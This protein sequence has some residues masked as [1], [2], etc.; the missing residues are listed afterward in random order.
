MATNGTGS[1]MRTSSAIWFTRRRAHG[2]LSPRGPDAHAGAV[3]T[4]PENKERVTFSQVTRQLSTAR[5]RPDVAEGFSAAQRRQGPLR[6]YR[7]LSPFMPWQGTRCGAGAQGLVG[8][9]LSSACPLRWSTLL[10]RGRHL[11]GQALN[12]PRRRGR[13][14]ARSAPKPGTSMAPTQAR[15][16]QFGP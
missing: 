2:D 14:R 4:L 7:P 11:A 16:C 5:H 6:R 8:E 12:Q 13:G 10:G 1:K 9:P 3:S 15:R